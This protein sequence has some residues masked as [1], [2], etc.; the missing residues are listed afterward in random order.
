MFYRVYLHREHLYAVLEQRT[1][2]KFY[3]ECGMF[4]A[5]LEDDCVFLAGSV[6]DALI[7]S[8]D[9]AQVKGLAAF[10]NSHSRGVAACVQLYPDQWAT[11]H[12]CPTIYAVEIKPQ[13]LDLDKLTQRPSVYGCVEYLYPEPIQLPEPPTVTELTPYEWDELTRRT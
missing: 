10:W 6:A 5:G 8:P 1:I 12:H 2:P 7:L 13:W 11:I 4:L 3:R 9:T